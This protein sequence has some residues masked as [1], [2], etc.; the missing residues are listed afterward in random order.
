MGHF[1]ASIL[2]PDEKVKEFISQWLDERDFIEAHT[3]GSTGTPKLIH[4]LKSDM[5]KSA[6]AT[7][8]FFG[9]GKGDLL[10]CPLSCGYIAGKMMLVRAFNAE[11][12]VDFSHDVTLPTTSRIKLMSVVPA[13]IQSL[14]DSPTVLSNIDNLLI[15]GS[16]LSDEL[17]QKLVDKGINA[18]VSYGMT[19]TCSHIAI[20]KC[21]ELYYTTL[22]GINISVDKDNR[23]KVIAPQFSFNGIT[24]NDVIEQ[25]TDSTFRWL[26]RFDNAIISG[27][28]KV[29]AEQIEQ[30][31]RPYLPI[32]ANFYITWQNHIRWGQTVVMVS[33]A[34]IELCDE[35]IRILSPAERP[36]K[37]IIGELKYTPSGKI[38]RTPIKSA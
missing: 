26:G 13:Q 20:R 35:C 23:L 12:M 27:G 3:S 25:I 22:P 15:G 36:R 1:S 24:T 6:I 28:V 18:Y 2:N 9:I 32:G 8:S 5:K 29:F 21:G 19:E 37:I 34:P 7:N 17:E 4:L 10:R 30:K 38:I 31:I 16:P 11:A 14:L 33:D